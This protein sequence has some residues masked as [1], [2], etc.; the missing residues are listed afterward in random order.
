VPPAPGCIVTIPLFR[1][2]GPAN[3]ARISVLAISVSSSRAVVS[4]SPVTS[5]PSWWSSSRASTS[6]SVPLSLLARERVSSICFRLRSTFWVCSRL[7]QKLGSA[8]CLSISLSSDCL[9][10]MSKILPEVSYTLFQVP[11]SFLN[12]VKAHR[13]LLFA[14]FP[15]PLGLISARGTVTP[16]STIL[17][18]SP[19]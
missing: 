11:V 4:R 13:L 6:S 18:H 7:F 3:S 8:I 15:R 1:S 9:C 14:V 10:S 12:I 17:S 5:S 19:T 2:W 16:T